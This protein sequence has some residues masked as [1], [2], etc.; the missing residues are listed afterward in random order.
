MMRIMVNQ[1]LSPNRLP[2]RKAD[3]ADRAPMKMVSKTEK[4]HLAEVTKLLLNPNTN[5]KNTD[6]TM[7]VMMNYLPSLMSLT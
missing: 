5:K 6:T 1:L 4:Y 2:T 7:V 3:P